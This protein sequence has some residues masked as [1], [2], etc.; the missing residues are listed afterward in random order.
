MLVFIMPIVYTGLLGLICFAVIDP[1]V[2]SKSF[3][4]K[5]RVEDINSR[6]KMVRDI[7]NSNLLIGK[8]QREVIEIL[9]KDFKENCWGKNTW[10]YVAYD[11]DNYAPLD[12]YEFIVFFN[13]DGT[14]EKAEY[15]LI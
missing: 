14:V 10:C 4:K 8:T 11:P 12:H 6:Y 1:I 13:E 2:R 9:G 3:E 15:K 5:L 7:N